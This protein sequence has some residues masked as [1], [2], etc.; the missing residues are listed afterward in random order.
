MFCAFQNLF[1]NL[2]NMLYYCIVIVKDIFILKAD[3][4]Y[5]MFL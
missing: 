5:A 3:C 1:R 4:V 2:T